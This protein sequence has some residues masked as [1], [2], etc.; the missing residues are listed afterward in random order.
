MV[1]L[2]EIG[3]AQNT[4]VAHILQQEE[5]PLWLGTNGI[6]R[7]RIDSVGRVGINKTNPTT[8]LDVTEL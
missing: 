6:E 4:G 3:A 8:T 2:L 5:K 1:W 7:V